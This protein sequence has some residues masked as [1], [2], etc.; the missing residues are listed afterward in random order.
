MDS[1]TGKLLNYRQLIKNPK[2]KKNWSTSSANK[3]GRL[4]NGVH[5]RIKNPA[6][7]IT[8]IR[9]KEIPNKPQKRC[10]IRKVHLQR[11]AI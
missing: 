6:N 4:A 10:H 11:A 3:F 1:E 5:G 7:T 2:Y 8:F 9:R